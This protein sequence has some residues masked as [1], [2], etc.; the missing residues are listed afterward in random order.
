MMPT[1]V[2]EV[3]ISVSVYSVKEA[4][5]EAVVEDFYF[6]IDCVFSLPGKPR[7]KR[8]HTHLSLEASTWVGFALVGQISAHL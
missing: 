1:R 6:L 5:L 4:F 3:R 8:S 2:Q 7:L